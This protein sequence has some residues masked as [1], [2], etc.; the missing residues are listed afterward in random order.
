MNQDIDQVAKLA[1]LAEKY[2]IALIF[3]LIFLVAMLY[4]M[5]MVVTGK[6]VP[7]SLLDKVEHDRDELLTALIEQKDTYRSIAGV[8]SNL[9]RDDNPNE[10]SG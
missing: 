8:V 1:Q 4:V 2:G 5:R 3:A 7:R 10:R 6:L 9:K